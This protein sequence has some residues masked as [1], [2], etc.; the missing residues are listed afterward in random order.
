MKKTLKD[1]N[2]S[3]KQVIM[4][5]DFNVPL[6]ENQVIDNKRIKEALKSINF[7]L[8]QNAKI[9]LISHLGRPKGEQNEAYFKKYSLAPVAKELAKLLNKSVQFCKD[10]NLQ[11]I[12]EKVVKLKE[13][14]I[15]LLENIRFLE[16]ETSKSQVERKELAKELA[17]FGD[18]YVNDAFGTV[19]RNQA[20]SDIAYFLPS[21]C[22]F[23]IENEINIL[24]KAIHKP[25]QPL[26]IILGGAKVSDKIPVI[27]YLVEKVDHILIGGGMAY[28]FLKAKGY[29]IGKSLL[30]EELICKC[31][32]L[33]ENYSEKILLPIDVVLGKIDFSSM[34]SQGNFVNTTI[35][36]ISSESEGLDIGEKTIELFSHIILKSNTILWNGPMGVFECEQAANGT[37][38]IAKILAKVTKNGGISIIGGGDSA[39]AVK[40]F[41]LSENFSHISTGGGASLEFLKGKSLPG[42]AIISNQAN[43]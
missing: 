27:E 7:L 14:D 42:I 19:H 13:Q 40:K 20:S 23:L 24:T 9:I 30:E 18:I 39:S 5:V 25:K 12:Q 38:E 35:N 41:N 37:K 33:L 8:N 28:T 10:L 32:E 2:F 17:N 15:L 26:T 43:L 11:T 36:N 6:K 3:N 1:F 22:G 34:K 4:R 16:A 31:K 21:C 29:E